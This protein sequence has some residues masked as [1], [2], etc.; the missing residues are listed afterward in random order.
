MELD[1]VAESSCGRVV[2]V[3]VKKWKTKIGKNLVEDFVEK[4]EVYA[5]QVPE[6]MVLPTFL[7][8]GGFTDE[9]RQFCQ[10]R[11]I[12]TAERIAHF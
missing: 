10:E 4:V 2:V 7:S 5:T 3:E 1:V 8:L 11:G 9:A 6:K 12:G